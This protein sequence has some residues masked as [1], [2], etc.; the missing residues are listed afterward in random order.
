MYCS[1]RGG[2]FKKLSQRDRVHED[3]KEN[4]NC[5]FPICDRNAIF[6]CEGYSLSQG[7]NLHNFTKNMTV[8][9]N[10]LLICTLNTGIQMLLAGR[11]F[12]K[13][14]QCEESA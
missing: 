12:S 8:S 13:G 10:C 11:N 5:M 14:Q 9:S 3:L 1:C 2:L 6:C 7:N 4:E